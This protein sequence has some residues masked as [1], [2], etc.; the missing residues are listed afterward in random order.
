VVLTGSRDVRELREN[1]A[2]ADRGPLTPGEMA[3]MREFGRV[4]RG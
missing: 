4:V 2:A 1:V 3:F